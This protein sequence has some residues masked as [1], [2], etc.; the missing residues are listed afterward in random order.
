MRAHMLRVGQVIAP[1]RA[2]VLGVQILHRGRQPGA[3]VHAVGDVADRD[4]VFAV[5]RPQHLPRLARDPAV[6]RATRRS[7]SATS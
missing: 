7:R 5:V 1:I 6:Q 3:D 4:L 2:H